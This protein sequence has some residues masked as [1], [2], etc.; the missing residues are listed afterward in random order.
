LIALLLTLT[1]RRA[2]A[3][4]PQCNVQQFGPKYKRRTTFCTKHFWCHKTR[5]TDLFTRYSNCGMTVLWTH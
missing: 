3:R 2:V 5:S 1:S 4:R